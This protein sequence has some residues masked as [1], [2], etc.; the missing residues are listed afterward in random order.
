MEWFRR[1]LE[2]KSGFPMRE[3]QVLQ[4][5]LNRIRDF[6]GSNDSIFINSSSGTQVDIALFRET[7][8]RIASMED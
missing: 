6:G 5:D 2:K 3:S 4:T 1:F 8:V 7:Y